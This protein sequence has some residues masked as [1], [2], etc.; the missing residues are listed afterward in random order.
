MA[1]NTIRTKDGMVSITTNTPDLRKIGKDKRDLLKLKMSE[2][3]KEIAEAGVKFMKEA[4]RDTDTYASGKLHDAVTEGTA[5]R[6]DKNFQSIIYFEDVDYAYYADQGRDAGKPPPISAMLDWADD[7]G[8][9]EKD[10]FRI[11]NIIAQYGTKGKHFIRRAE[12]KL[13]RRAPEIF[14]KKMKEFNYGN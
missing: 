8:L 3:N 4:I 13:S 12:R 2:A 11:R 6:G 1:R 7:V 14:D 9:S 10:A 5:Q